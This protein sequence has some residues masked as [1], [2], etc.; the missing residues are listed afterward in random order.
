MTGTD[1][2]RDPRG[3]G[4]DGI[5]AVVFGAG[6]GIGGE[7]ARL[8]AARG[9]KVMLGDRDAEVAAQAHDE[10]SA[11]G[12][13]DHGVVDVTDRSSI[14][15]FL[16]AAAESVGSPRI[17]VDVVGRAQAKPF[18]DV[19]DDDWDE[20][21]VLNLRQQFLVAQESLEL[22]ADG[23][24][25]T[26]IGSING[27]LSSPRNVPYGAAKAGLGSLTRSLAVE[28][29]QRGVRVNAVTPSV[30]LT[31]RL[32]TFLTETGR[33]QEFEASIPMGRASSPVEVA[34]VAVFL[35]SPLASYVTGQIVG[36]DGGA[37]V[38]YPLATMSAD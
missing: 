21:L 18:E 8:L 11:F 19:T 37:S 7:I 28:Y 10:L 17:V 23:G 33:L 32:R 25:L 14:R 34:E 13:V 20:M 5:P 1:E 12:E 30:A 31:P 2:A 35:S 6:P 4:L 3:W 38:K 24:A 27:G 15:S 9:A 22:L 36:V 29:A 16:G 26:F